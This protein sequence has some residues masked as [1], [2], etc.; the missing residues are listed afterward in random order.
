MTAGQPNH[1]TEMVAL[2]IYDTFYSRI[3]FEGVAQAK[4]VVFTLVVAIISLLQ[5]FL[6]R[7]KEVEN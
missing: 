1:Q 3:G 6:T 7:R 2:N 4:A 5:L